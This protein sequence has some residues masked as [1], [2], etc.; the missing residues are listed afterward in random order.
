M[1]YLLFGILIWQ[2][3]CQT[4]AQQTVN[5]SERAKAERQPFQKSK[6]ALRLPANYGLRETE[7]RKYDPRP[8]IVPINEKAGQYELRWIG[9]DGKEKVIKYQRAD[10]LDAVVEASAVDAGSGKFNY[11]YLIRN[12]PQSPVFLFDF[13]VQTEASD[14]EV[15]RSDRIYVG[16]MAQ[17]IPDFSE[18]KWFRFVPREENGVKIDPGDEIEFDLTSPALPGIVGCRATGGEQ[19]LKGVGEDMPTELEMSTPAHDG[20]AR[21][22]TIGPVDRLAA[23]SPA[24][25]AQYLL[26]NLP[27]FEE[28]GWMSAAT[29]GIYRSLLAQPNLNAAAAQAKKDLAEGYITSEVYA[30]VEGLSRSRTVL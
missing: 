13:T 28:A 5:G 21:G 10:A 23:L 15:S 25:R 22:Y 26:D 1:R 18:G 24:Q 9:R 16:Q 6:A 12:L 14:I 27:K 30:I 4:S 8:R 19:T 11:K 29:A 3:A 2:L 20:W 17:F 7:K